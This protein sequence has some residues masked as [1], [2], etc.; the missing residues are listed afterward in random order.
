MRLLFIS[1]IY[2]TPGNPTHGTFNANLM[3]A[4]AEDHEVQVVCPVAWPQRLKAAMGGHWSTPAVGAANSIRLH[5]QTPTYFYPP[6][7]L[8]PQSGWFYW[9]SAR[10]ALRRACAAG[11]VDAV[12]SYWIHPDGEAAIRLAHNLNVPSVVMV[13]GSDLLLL[14]KNAAR[15]RRI[16]SVLQQVDLALTVSEHLRCKAIAFGV[17]AGKVSVFRQGVDLERFHPGNQLEARKAVSIAADRPT[18]LWVGRMVPVKALDVMLEACV[19]LRQQ[20]PKLNVVLV[21][22][23]PLRKSLEAQAAQLGLTGCVQFA[24]AQPQNGLPDWYRAADVMVLPSLSEGRPNVLREAVVCGTPFVASNVGGISEIAE[25]GVD[26]LVPAGQ[27]EPLA[28]AILQTLQRGRP[29]ARLHRGQSWKEAAAN[30]IE[31]IRPLTRQRGQQSMV[32]LAKRV[33]SQP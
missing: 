7:I 25:P 6:G 27:S 8:H 31:M 12:V 11:P 22:D 26:A 21:G 32:P 23:G 5:V 30:L 1:S 24:G 15:K 2:P 10:A 9:Q 16:L 28:N 3:R 4:L 29:Q 13:G 33:V 17:D 18:L 19:R 14:T 20:V